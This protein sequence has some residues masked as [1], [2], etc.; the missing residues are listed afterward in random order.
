MGSKQIRQ[1]FESPEIEPIDK[2]PPA[3]KEQLLI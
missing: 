1:L 3:K 2:I